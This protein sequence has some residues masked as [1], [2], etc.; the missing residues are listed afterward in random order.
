MDLADVRC[1]LESL[2]RGGF[3]DRHGRWFLV[4]T[5]PEALDSFAEFVDTRS[6]TGHDVLAG[7]RER[8]RV[9]IRPLK[10]RDGGDAVTIGREGA[11]IVLPSAT[12]SKTHAL[13]ARGGGL[14]C[15]TDSGSKNGTWINGVRLWPGRAMP[16]DVGDTLQFASVTAT[17]WSI[18]DLCAAVE[19]RPPAG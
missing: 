13:F 19:D 5:T 10:P 1:E 2:G 6:R 17:L 8:E 7:H 9:D 15:L 14:P 11:D 12:M 16:I 4:V 3:V 18:D